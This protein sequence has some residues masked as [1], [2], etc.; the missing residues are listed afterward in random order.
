MLRDLAT[1]TQLRASR[2]HGP[3]WSCDSRL[4]PLP[5]LPGPELALSVDSVSGWIRYLCAP[6]LHSP[7]RGPPVTFSMPPAHALKALL[8]A[9]V[10]SQN[11]LENSLN[12][13]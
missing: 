9:A 7:C 2:G 8:E 13:P 5:E 10:H 4:Q 6:S 3:D 12:G 1:G 11:S